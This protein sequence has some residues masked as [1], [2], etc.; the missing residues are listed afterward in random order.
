MSRLPNFIYIG[1][2]KAGSTWLYSVLDHHPDVYM[3]PGKALYF[4]SHH[5]RRGTQW[6]RNQF[7]LASDQRIVGEVS[8]TYM[9]CKDVSHR[10]A[11]MNADIRL[12]VCLREPADR[13][14]SD[15]LDGVKN[16]QIHC[17]FDDALQQVPALVDR[18]RYAKYLAPYIELFGREKI[19]VAVFDELKANANEFALKLFRF[20]DI[21]KRQLPASQTNKMMPAGQPRSQLMTKMTKKMSHAARSLGLRKLRG[22][23]KTSRLVRNM[24][25]RP[26]SVG[27]KPRMS[28]DTEQRLRALFKEDI[29]ELDS[30]LA[31]NLQD[32]WGYR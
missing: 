17:G 8:H 24:L 25:Y 26:Y 2:N 32:A 22:K 7:K 18:G 12:M 3:A 14:F 4:F 21:E 27:D 13:A 29:C 11:A 16:G 23:A 1:T 5:Y 19:H 31:T 9:Y 30:L 28:S 10:I 6:Y 20:L 15:Y